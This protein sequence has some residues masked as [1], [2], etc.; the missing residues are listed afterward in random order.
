M[1]LRGAEAKKERAFSSLAQVHSVLGLWLFLVICPRLKQSHPG[2]K[3]KTPWGISDRGNLMQGTDYNHIGRTESKKRR[4]DAQRLGALK[5]TPALCYWRHWYGFHGRQYTPNSCYYKDQDAALLPSSLPPDSWGNLTS[6][7][8]WKYSLLASSPR[9]T[10]Q[11]GE[12]G[13]H[14]RMTDT[15][16]P[17]GPGYSAQKPLSEPC[18]R[19]VWATISR[20]SRDGVVCTHKKNH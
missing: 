11:Q 10:E 14:R 4:E 13:R 7:R 16:L 12:A 19:V 2:G 8:I 3:A 18:G 15:W 5:P 20:G 17:C 1:I 6:R 9:G